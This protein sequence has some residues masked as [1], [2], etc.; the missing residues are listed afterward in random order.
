MKLVKIFGIVMAFHAAAFMFIFAI[1]GC[2][3]TTKKPVATAPASGSE[4]SP[5]AAAEAPMAPAG[6]SEIS[7]VRFSPTRPGTAAA[8]QA[9]AQPEAT[10]YTVAKGDNLWSI[11]KKNNVTV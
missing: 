3:S 8:A 4:A 7:S 2:R 1:P 11:A 6:T 5:L 10:T 9:V